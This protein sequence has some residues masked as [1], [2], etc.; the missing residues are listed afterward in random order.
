MTDHASYSLKAL[1]SRFV[2]LGNG[3]GLDRAQAGRW[4]AHLILIGLAFSLCGRAAFAANPPG[5]PYSMIP[6]NRAVLYM[7]GRGVTQSPPQTFGIYKPNGACVRTGKL[8]EVEWLPPGQYEIRVGFPTG[9]RVFETELRP[10][11]SRVIPT[12]L[13][14]FRH[15]DSTNVIT[16]IPQSLYYETNY[17]TT[18]YA[19]SGARLLAGKYTVRY[20]ILGEGSTKQSLTNWQIIGPFPTGSTPLNSLQVPYPPEQGNGR[21]WVLSNSIPQVRHSG[22][23]LSNDPAMLSAETNVSDSVAYGISLVESD[24][25]KLVQILINRQAP[26]K[27]WL[28]GALIHCDEDLPGSSGSLAL[29]QK[30]AKGSNELMIKTVRSGEDWTVR[31]EV[32]P[33]QTYE[34]NVVSESDPGPFGIH[35]LPTP[36]N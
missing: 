20:P 21:D 16:G 8:G 31:A 25:E 15:V 36:G 17:L 1:F 23:S 7:S 34:I 2:S 3:G 32:V 9:Y 4:A 26:V 19:G 11:E 10:G 33:C 29:N 18:A 12:G 27:I 14:T 30:L 5:A 6:K 35:P 13:F 24:Q 22:L 28:N